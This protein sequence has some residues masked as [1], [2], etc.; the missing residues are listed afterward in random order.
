KK[1]V[2]FICDVVL[3]Y[4]LL[5]GLIFILLP[6]ELF[7]SIS[8][9]NFVFPPIVNMLA[10]GA[11][12]IGAV[13]ILFMSGR[14]S[15]NPALRIALGAHDL[16]NITGWVSDVL[17]YSRLLALGLATGVI[18]S[19]INQMG[20]MVGNSVLDMIVFVIVFI[21]G[22]IF[23]LGINVLGAYVH[24]CRLQYVEFFG[25]FYEGGGKMF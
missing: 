22:H 2:D 8:Q 25:K 15:K 1:Y 11:A 6:T 5:T 24:T 20:S 12:I 14:S 4:F 21:G 9:M 18:A 13:G 23:N 16:Y 19:V 7:S 3:W 17:S 10:K